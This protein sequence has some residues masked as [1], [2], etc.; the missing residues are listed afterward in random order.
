MTES[1]RD[2]ACYMENILCCTVCHPYRQCGMSRHCVFLLFKAN[3]N[4]VSDRPRARRRARQARAVVSRSVNKTTW[5]IR[6]ESTRIILINICNAMA[7]S[8]TRTMRRFNDD[9]LSEK[10]LS[11]IEHGSKMFALEAKKELDSVEGAPGTPGV[12]QFQLAVPIAGGPRPSETSTASSSSG[13][14]SGNP[15][16]ATY[17]PSKRC[18]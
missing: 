11:M 17:D 8:A 10:L 3:S 16:Q 18:S 13:R 6:R 14:A 2:H 15:M 5:C 12:R 4:L 9:Q 7:R 1:S